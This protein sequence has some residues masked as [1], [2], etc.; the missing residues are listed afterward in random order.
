[1]KYAL[2][3]KTI[4]SIPEPSSKKRERERELDL[5]GKFISRPA[6]SRAG[7]CCDNPGSDS[8]KE[9]S[10]AL[11]SIQQLAAVQEAANIPNLWIRGRA[12]CL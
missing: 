2:Q 5:L 10:E 11:P 4:V 1:M 6:N 12:S 7:H 9:A 8:L 3:K